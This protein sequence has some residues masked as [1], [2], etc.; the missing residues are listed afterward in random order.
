MRASHSPAA[1]SAS[2]MSPNRLSWLM[3][4][5]TPHLG[6]T[7]GAGARTVRLVSRQTIRYTSSCG[8]PN[9]SSTAVYVHLPQWVA[10]DP[11]FC[12][13]SQL[14]QLLLLQQ[15]SN[16]SYPTFQEFSPKKP[17]CSSKGFSLF[18]ASS[19][20]ARGTRTLGD[21]MTVPG[22]ERLHRDAPETVQVPLATRAFVLKATAV[23]TNKAA[24]TSKKIE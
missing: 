18:Q 14:N 9:T 15:M 7:G 2:I 13:R 11:R 20:L 24:V 23:G 12:T 10:P 8:C 3:G 6:P 21:E 4:G 19:L 17:G 22:Y 5:V 16:H 1:C